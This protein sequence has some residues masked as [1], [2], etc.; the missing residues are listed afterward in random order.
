MMGRAVD[1]RSLPALPF[2]AFTLRPFTGDRLMLV[3][4]EAPR[5]AKT[6]PHAHPHE[7][8]CLVISG[9]LRFRIGD[10]E[11]VLG[12]FE[13]IHIPSGAEHEAEALDAVVF[14]DIFHPVRE[15]YLELLAPSD[16]RA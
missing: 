6:P 1:T 7:Q 2:G 4:V 14:Y 3:R 5:G 8:M 16:E 11:R 10:E 9:R 12:P 15:D 13:A